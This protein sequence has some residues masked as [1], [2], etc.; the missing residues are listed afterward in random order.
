MKKRLIMSILF[1]FLLFMVGCREEEFGDISV[2]LIDDYIETSVETIITDQEKINLPTYHPEYDCEIKWESF[3]ERYIANNGAIVKKPNKITEVALLYTLTYNDYV[4][5]EE[6]V[7]TIYP[8]SIDKVAMQFE[9][10]FTIPIQ[11]SYTRIKTNYYDCYN[12]TWYSTNQAIFSNSGEYTKPKVDT[13]FEIIYKVSFLGE[14]KE[15]KIECHSSSLSALEK[16]EKTYDWL[17]SEGGILHETVLIEDLEISNYISKYGVHLDIESSNLDVIDNNGK[18]KRSVYR[19]F[20]RL[21]LKLSHSSISRTYELDIE[22]KEIDTENLNDE[23][24]LN[25]FLKTIARTTYNGVKYGYYDDIKTPKGKQW[26]INKSF[27][28]LSFYK[29]DYPKQIE[30]LMKVNNH[31]LPGTKLKS[32]EFIVMHDTGSTGT[33]ENHKNALLNTNSKTSFHY[34]VDNR[35]IYHLVKDDLYA[36]HAGCG[37]REFKMIDTKVKA[38]NTYPIIEIDSKGYYTMNGKKTNI[39]A[40]TNNGK[41]LSTKDIVDYGIYTSIGANG[42]YYMNDSYYN[43]TYKKISNTGG[44]I[45]GLGIEMCVVPNE[46]YII[47][48]RNT[49]KLVAKLLIKNNLNLD[50]IVQHNHFSGKDCPIAIRRASW[51]NEFKELVSLERYALENFKDY[52]FIWT[53][54]DNKLEDTGLIDADVKNG[55]ILS[56]ICEVKKSGKTILKTNYLTKIEK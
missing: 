43:S 22:V 40:P 23:D 10:Q 37:K 48:V 13:E 49:A 55:E 44:G 38:S 51:W 4:K 32:V 30:S 15:F 16:V 8:S 46:D 6:I 35:E 45:N 36:Y 53:S 14:E 29:N 34:C 2:G 52:D 50:R 31:N 27:G 18:I 21:K 11:R 33:A 7:V 42:N 1:S 56:Y 12:I 3:D 28:F 25:L 20:A 41:I 54:K 5:E 39:K 24:K 17:R 47:T 9:N 26:I 19:R